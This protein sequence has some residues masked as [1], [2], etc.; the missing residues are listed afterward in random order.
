ML[1]QPIV[2]LCHGIVVGA[3]NLYQLDEWMAK[4]MCVLRGYQKIP[5][6][7]ANIIG[8]HYVQLPDN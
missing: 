6:F 1:S 2:Y 5:I 7:G 3:I 4:D 8:S